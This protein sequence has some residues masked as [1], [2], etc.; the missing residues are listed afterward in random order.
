MAYGNKEGDYTPAFSMKIFPADLTGHVQIEVDL[1]LADNDTRSHRCCFFVKTELGMVE[2]FGK[3]LL[4][5]I[6]D[7]T[8]T[9]IS[10]HEKNCII[11]A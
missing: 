11:S 1:E 3:S 8:D 7:H 10:L 6:S 2:A 9:E 4:G 5:L